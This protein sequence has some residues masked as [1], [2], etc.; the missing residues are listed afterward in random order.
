MFNNLAQ[1]SE[2]QSFDINTIKPQDHER[3]LEFWKHNEIKVSELKDKKKFT[4][5]LASNPN[6]SSI[7]TKD[8]EIAGVILTSFDGMIGYIY[9]IAVSNNFR[10]NGIGKLMVNRSTNELK[11]LGASR[12][13]F[14][15]KNEN[16]KGLDFWKSI[17]ADK[18][19]GR[20]AM[21]I[22]L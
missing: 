19:D 5:F 3:L 16:E 7:V 2:F 17:G 12:C 21:Q 20:F 22:C 6:L 10:G 15:V 8:N 18:Y 11:S 1:T 4:F 13:Q 14:F 9:H